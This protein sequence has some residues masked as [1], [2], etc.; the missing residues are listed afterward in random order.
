MRVLVA[1]ITAACALLP[2]QGILTTSRTFVT[3]TAPTSSASYDAGASA[4]LTTLAGTAVANKTVTGCTWVNSLG[5]SGA[6]TGTTSW[7]VPSIA[8]TAGDNVITV[9]CANAGGTGQDVITVTAAPSGDCLVAD[10]CFPKPISDGAGATGI[11]SGRTLSGDCTANPSSGATIRDCTFSGGDLTT[12]GAG[13]TYEYVRFLTGSDSMIHKG[14]GT[15]TIRYSTFGRASGCSDS[16]VY[17]E[18]GG[19]IVEY[20]RWLSTVSEGPRVSASN[21]TIR[22]NFI[23]PMCSAPGDHADGV[24]GFHGGSNIFVIHN[25]VDQRTAADTTAPIFMSDHSQGAF[26][27]DNLVLGGTYSLKMDNDDSTSGTLWRLV[28]NRIGNGY[29]LFGPIAVTNWNGTCTNNKLVTIDSNYNITS[30]L[31]TVGC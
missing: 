13:A 1:F 7:S 4:A 19:Y 26:V 29:W 11:P 31:S 22:H 30:T 20:N 8:L 12:T 9:T 6:A 10:D 24:Q 16:I 21:I 27:E 23:G 25:T 14:S 15:L 18:A 17:E 2:E 3:I 28:N 5:G